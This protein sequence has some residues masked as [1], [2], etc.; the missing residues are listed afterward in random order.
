MIEIID[1]NGGHMKEILNGYITDQSFVVEKPHDE[2]LEKL[3]EDFHEDK[4]KSLFY[5]ALENKDLALSPCLLFLQEMGSLYIK[6]L[7]RL[8][9]IELA[10][11]H[12][13]YELS[14][15]QIE[16]LLESLPYLVGMEHVTESWVKNQCEALLGVFKK[17]IK[18]SDQTVSGFFHEI[19][20]NLHVADKV[21]F[22]L[23]EQ[24]DANY[25]FAFM[26]TY[27]V[28]KNQK[29]QHMPLKHAFD[30]FKKDQPTLIKLIASVIQA[31]E[32]SHFISEIL[33]SGE[34]FSPIGLTKEEAYDFL[35]DIEVFE[36]YNIMCRIPNWWKKR[37]K[38]LSVQVTIGEKKPSLVGLE[39]LLD[40][41]PQVY[42]GDQVL[43][44]E[45]L[46]SF[47]ALAEGLVQFKGQW[48]EVSQK[49][50][51]KIKAALEGFETATENE[52]SVRDALQL[53]LGLNH[54]VDSDDLPI[55]YHHGAWLQS[56][57][58]SLGSSESQVYPIE[59]TFVASLRHYQEVGYTWLNQMDDFKLGACLADDMGLGKTIQVIAFLDRVRKVNVGKALIVM[60]AS[61]LSNWEKEILK[62]AP[63]IPYKTLH[64]SVNKK[65]N[66]VLDDTFLY[67]TTYG[68]VSK[69]EV[70]NEAYFDY[71]I[72]DEAQ[73]IKNPNSKQ[74]KAIKNLKYKMPIALTGTPIENNLGD[75]WSL[76]DF[77]NKGL[78]GNM[79]E[80]KKYIKALE[81]HPKG[82][83]KLRQ[84]IQPFILRRMKTDPLIAPDLPGKQEINT[85][86][87]LSQKQRVLYKKLV[88]DLEGQLETSEGIQRRG[89]V[90]ATIMKFKQI[91]NHPDQF[92]GMG[93][94]SPKH[95]GKFLQ[96]KD[97]CETIYE[98][99]ERVLIFTQFKEM[100]EHISN[101]LEEVFKHKGLVL[102][103]GTPVKKRQEMVDAFNGED[104]VPFM[105][106]SLKAGG[107]GLNLTGAN[108]VIHFDRWWNPAVENQA[109]DRA[110][111]IGQKK[112]V[113][114]Y[115]F[116]T[117]GTIEE[118]IDMMIQDKIKL[119]TELLADVGEKWITEFS[120]E[121]LLDIF[122]LGG[123]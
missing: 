79:T 82:Y 93:E 118:K 20:E 91:C 24:R 11:E 123:Q 55:V 19:S 36:K 71:L 18:E 16:E 29:A 54:S 56:F 40:F 48:I 14:K 35:R 80:F 17:L 68:M 58:A 92:M 65:E 76:F 88:K 66:L 100:T 64:S 121:E 103:G 87:N 78:L 2:S 99:R 5:L 37:S 59:N 38:Q 60:P 104:Y 83:S 86:T 53:Q 13:E 27:S 50:L 34:L 62:F 74:T 31:S 73:A 102:H 51:D 109:T 111:R 10:R 67:L 39:G 77:L 72:L 21:Y 45:E 84:T 85:Y 4:Y 114:V 105:V 70:L 7:I 57:T 101:F 120:N 49:N 42:I 28:K 30:H 26:A 33:A 52:L 15:E 110:F 12:I 25:P 97:I 44:E 69:L 95:S 61:L 89:L 6:N 94:Y 1:I 112:H 22:H 32:E 116:V 23:V 119:S 122:K 8:P 98:K 63:D 96:L 41:K 47:L 113:N 90:L 75:L 108:H 46:K 106:I 9:E 107:T 115:K 117:E 3:Y 43:T 81:K